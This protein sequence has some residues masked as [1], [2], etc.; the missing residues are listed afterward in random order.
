MTIEIGQRVAMLG[1]PDFHGI[2]VTVGKQAS[3][4]KWLDPHERGAF[5]FVS[6]ENLIEVT[7]H[8]KQ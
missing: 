5:Q 3:E 4:V 6:N 1:S 7:S 2:V 8:E